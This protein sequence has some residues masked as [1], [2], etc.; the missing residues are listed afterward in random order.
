M[1][2]VKANNAEKTEILFGQHDVL[3]KWKQCAFNTK[4]EINI[5]ADSGSSLETLGFKNYVEILRYLK[6][7]N[8]RIRYI[9]EISEQNS[10]FCKM[11][12]NIISEF[13][14]LDGIKG[15]FGVTDE[16]FLATSTL[17]EVKPVSHAIYSNA[18]Q[19]VEV[20]RHIFETL[21]N[22]SI[23][24]ERKLKEIE[25]GSE[26][27][28]FEV[29]NDPQRSAKIIT[30]LVGSINSEALL[31]LP[32]S[33]S[34][35]RLYRL[36]VLD[37]LSRSARRGVKVNIICPIDPQ[38]DPIVQSLR[39]NNSNI[40]V[41]NGPEGSVGLVVVDNSKF[42][43]S[44]VHEESD[45]E[46]SKTLGY[47]LYSNS[48]SVIQSIRLFFDLLWKSDELSEKLKD[49]ERVQ[50]EFI[51][52]ASHEIKTPIQSILTYSELLQSEPEKN[53]SYVDAIRRNALRLKLLSN[54]LLDM[55]KIQ[56]K[57]LVVHRDRFDLSDVALSIVEDFRNQMKSNQSQS[58]V[59]ISFSGP[60]H[61]IV[62]G[63]KERITQVISNLVHNALKFTGGGTIMLGLRKGPEEVTMS[64]KDTGQGIAQ[65]IMPHL[66]TKFTT[67]HHSGTG[68]GLYISK[69]IVEA[70]GGKIWG[71][72]NPNGRGA[73]FEFSLP[74]NLCMQ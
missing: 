29:I 26:P 40:N 21:W 19:L 25:E 44:E 32:L 43:I 16:E 13:R 56:S 18:K 68:V 48:A 31:L 54:N 30:N 74:L 62:E 9:T 24:A 15:A 17:Q 58:S 20:Q 41:L 34:L 3:E 14:H 52:I 72:N 38:S 4:V 36:G 73:T 57:T 66:F 12:M 27:E 47:G 67:K 65:N 37:Q 33:K 2:Y 45:I 35:V 55:T 10:Q 1:R 53:E 42:F 28:F 63:D 71:R 8:V 39:S 59:K 6:E 61:V 49:H 11:L 22:R 70:H 46:F 69:N 64:V 7:K 51:N 23:P 5:Y 60:D 50:T